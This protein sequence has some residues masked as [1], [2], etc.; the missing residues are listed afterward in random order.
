MKK[1]LLLFGLLLAPVQSWAQDE[2][3]NTSSKVLRLEDF[4][5]SGPPALALLGIAHASVARPNTPRALIASLVSATGSSGTVPN[6]YAIE[7]APYWLTSHPALDLD[8]YYR[9]TLTDRLRYF[10]AFSVATARRSARSDSVAPDARVSIAV[11][12][13]LMNGRP[14]TALLAVSDSM[15]K[16]QVQYI[17][18]YV[19][20]E[21]LR[22]TAGAL[23]S[24]QRRLERQE[25]LLSTLVTK[26][27][28]GPERDLRDSTLRTL[29]RRDSARA[30]VAVSQS[31]SDQVATLEK[32]M[33]GLEEKLSNLAE[34][35]SER[36]L[37]PDGFVLELAA[38]TRAL[39]SEGEWDRER[40]DGIGVWVTPMYRL[41]AS[42]L[43]VVGVTRYLTRVA[44]YADDDLLDLG[45][46][47]GLDIG[48]ASL[49][50]EWVHRSLMDADTGSSRWAA[51]F[52]YPLPAKLHLV[53][54][55]GSDFR[56]PNGKRPVVATLGINLG[57]GAVMILPE[58]KAH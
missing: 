25:S 13:L 28:V 37:E 26:V 45:V 57:L 43:E 21:T 29:A 53:A 8:R 5:L 33:D 7:T 49:S 4:R 39:F 41:S 16:A 56:R 17:T 40:V 46:R 52:D 1:T 51:L 42:H 22:V 12:T 48:K 32:Q 38:G 14:S 50:G 55:F 36:D 24:Q 27:L 3:T 10:T 30:A 15:R 2:D 6:G 58:S 18:R 44:E 9:A 31:A 20:W 34:S 11:R 35:F 54:S 23:A 19:Q 47:A